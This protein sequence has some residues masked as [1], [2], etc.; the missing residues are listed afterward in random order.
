MAQT[1]IHVIT[2]NTSLL[3]H[4]RRETLNCGARIIGE[5][6]RTRDALPAIRER[7]DAVVLIEL[8]EEKELED[9]NEIGWKVPLASIIVVTPIKT[10][11]WVL[12]LQRN[13]A[14]QVVLLPFDA[15]DF[16][17]A[18]QRV[19][20]RQQHQR[21]TGTVISVAGVTHGVGATFIACNLAAELGELL[22]EPVF[23]ADLNV[24]MGAVATY[25]DINPTYSLGDL[26]EY[27]GQLDRQIVERAI[28]RVGP[29]LNV[30]AAPRDWMGKDDIDLDRFEEILILMQ[31]IERL[32]VIDV[33]CTYDDMFFG[34]LIRSNL[35]VLVA[36]QEVS[37]IRALGQIIG[38]LYSEGITPERILV[39]INRHGAGDPKIRLEDIEPVIQHPINHRITND[40]QAAR[41]A[42]DH[43]ILLKD[44]Q[45]KN[46]L[47]SDV[48]AL[49]KRIG[50]VVGT[51]GNAVA[52]TFGSEDSSALSRLARSLRLTGR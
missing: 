12:K 52:P 36:A 31:G 48:I 16:G 43:G 27:S 11:E 37:A 3:P 46:Q 44:S 35:I 28:T 6:P 51:S 33:P 29:Y 14:S 15:E 45:T 21:G 32:A 40:Y 5:H 47:R 10:L 13:G 7:P 9:L 38:K 17:A 4:I 20:Y 23:V 26:L 50:A 8:N 22:T 19:N 30:L 42:I 25:L 18:I 1:L 39:V 24:N 49:A 41:T 34:C 2:Q